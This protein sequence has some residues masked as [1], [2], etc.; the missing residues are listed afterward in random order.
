MATIYLNGELFL[1][2]T[3]DAGG[4]PISGLIRDSSE[5]LILGAA[6]ANAYRQA[7][8]SYGVM[9]E[10]RIWDYARTE[11][12]I[13]DNY[14]RLVDP[15]EDGLIA[16]YNF[17]E[18][19]SS[20]SVNDLSGYHNNGVLDGAVHVPSTVMIIPEPTTVLLFSFGTLILRRK[21]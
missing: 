4:S 5:D 13:D 17:D 12:Q 19:L 1:S 8:F 6:L 2:T 21:Q 3:V 16:Y 10:V 7:E 18:S 14:N 15:N 11:S 9:D 20:Q